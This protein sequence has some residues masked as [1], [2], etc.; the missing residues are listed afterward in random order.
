M[1]RVG[2]SWE[3]GLERMKLIIALIQELPPGGVANVTYCSPSAW[4][5]QISLSIHS[6]VHTHSSE[7]ANTEALPGHA[8]D[9]IDLEE[10]VE[11]WHRYGTEDNQNALYPICLGEVLNEK[12]L[13][14]HKLG[15]GGGSTVWMAF[16]LQDK[17]DIALKVIALGKWGDNE[18][19]IQDE[20]IKT[21]QDT[22]RL[23]I[24]SP[25][26]FLPRDDENY[27][28]VMVFPM[29]GPSI[30]TLTIKRTNAPA[31]PLVQTSAV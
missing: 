26:F 15:F 30:C 29:R 6:A 1:D 11:P 16:D 13:V 28:R 10:F 22:S 9:F 31:S 27:H 3:F 4:A 21:G 19:R 8:S 12:Y 23:I 17:G 14:E 5:H 20:I 18:I 24:Y 2:R 7:M 25:T